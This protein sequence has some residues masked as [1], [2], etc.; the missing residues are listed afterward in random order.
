MPLLS[1]HTP[2]N[3][4]HCSPHQGKVTY[5]SKHRNNRDTLARTN[6]AKSELA[7]VSRDYERLSRRDGGAVSRTI[8]HGRVGGV[9]VL[10][11]NPGRDA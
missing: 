3:R 9:P 2:V 5:A 10:L 6:Q 1:L 7:L 11:P 8:M 4:S